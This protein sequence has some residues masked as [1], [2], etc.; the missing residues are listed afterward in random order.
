MLIETGCLA[1]CPLP[2]YNTHL[3]TEMRDDVQ[4]LTE[5]AYISLAINYSEINLHAQIKTGI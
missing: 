2:V 5:H 4:S 1:R 3:A